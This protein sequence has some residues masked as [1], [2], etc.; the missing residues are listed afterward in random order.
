MPQKLYRPEEII[1]KLRTADVLLGEG[2]QVPEVTK[3]LGIHE[4]T[5][6]RWRKEHDGLSLTHAKRVEEL[7]RENQRLC[8]AVSDLTTGSTMCRQRVGGRRAVQ[9]LLPQH[10]ACC[11]VPTIRSVNWLPKERSRPKHLWKR[12]ATTPHDRVPSLSDSKTASL[13]APRQLD[14]AVPSW[15]ASACCVRLLH[16]Q[17]HPAAFWC[18]QAVDNGHGAG[19]G[20]E[21]SDDV[22]GWASVDEHS[23]VV[24]EARKNASLDW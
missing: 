16:C 17:Q 20:I 1:A 6:Y 21:P 13:V 14:T 23:A 4:V 11:H 7:E 19:L 5:Y 9:E 24:A 18:G 22:L 15:R 3:A 2:E 10:Q 12:G 8:R